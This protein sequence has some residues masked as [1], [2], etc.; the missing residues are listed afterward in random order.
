[1]C[2]PS[3]RAITWRRSNSCTNVHRDAADAQ[4]AKLLQRR[5]KLHKDVQKGTEMRKD[6]SDDQDTQSC[7]EKSK[8]VQ[9]RA[10]LYKDV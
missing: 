6:A 5:A 8:V 2:S 7:A 3:M 4:D 1:M 10:K 9:R